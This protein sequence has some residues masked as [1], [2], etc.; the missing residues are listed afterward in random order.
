MRIFSH[1]RCVGV[2][3]SMVFV[4]LVVASSAVAASTGSL[5]GTVTDAT[6][7]AP[8]ANECVAAL[9]ASNNFVASGITDSAGRYTVSGLA[10][11]SYKVGFQSCGGGNYLSQFYD[12]KPSLTCLTWQL[13]VPTTGLMHSDHCQPG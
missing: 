5:L 4:F 8:V 3:T 12:N 6:T 13:S 9:D 11:G 7:G 10:A 2:L 1:R